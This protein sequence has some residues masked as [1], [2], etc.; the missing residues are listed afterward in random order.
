MS[1]RRTDGPP[2]PRGWGPRPPRGPPPGRP[3]PGSPPQGSPPPRGR[4]RWPWVLLGLLLL[5]LGGC[6]VLF[7]VLVHQ[8]SEDAGRPARVTYAATGR[9]TGVTIT[10]S[11]WHDGN[12]ATS[13]VGDQALPWTKEIA[14]KGFTKGGSLVVTL[15]ARGGAATCSVTVDDRPPV[16]ASAMG[17]FASAVCTGF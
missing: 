3:P 4:R 9:A 16:T 12:A 2:G 7:T 13:Q 11:T 10:Y 1:S 6:A 5:L 14:T 17:P 8:V 15:G